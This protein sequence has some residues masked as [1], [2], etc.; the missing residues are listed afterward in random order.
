M[1]TKSNKKKQN[2]DTRREHTLLVILK[3]VVS[4]RRMKIKIKKCERTL[5][6]RPVTWQTLLATS[7]MS[8]DVTTRNKTLVVTSWCL[9]K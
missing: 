7:K 8:F 3:W 4:E 9:Q 1:K 6:T 5:Y 2:A